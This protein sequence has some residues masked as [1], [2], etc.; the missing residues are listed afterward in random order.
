MLPGG[1]GNTNTGLD[2]LFLTVPG[3][4]IFIDIT[5]EIVKCLVEKNY[6]KWK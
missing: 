5:G 6:T 3:L 4:T 1:F 2:G